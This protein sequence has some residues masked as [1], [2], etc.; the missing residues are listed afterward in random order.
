MIS[1]ER[2]DGDTASSPRVCIR[3]AAEPHVAVEYFLVEIDEQESPSIVL[4][5]PLFVVITP[6]VS[7]TVLERQPGPPFA[8][9]LAERVLDVVR[10]GVA[11]R[12][13]VQRVNGGPVA[14]AELEVAA[15]G[16]GKTRQRRDD[17]QDGP[18]ANRCCIL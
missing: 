9:R 8:E 15:G 13:F 12:Q 14:G 2:R 6:E 10:G 4:Q 11:D 3:Q 7:R 5:R 16:D 17:H 18:G 1:A